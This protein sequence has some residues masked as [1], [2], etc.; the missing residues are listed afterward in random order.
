MGDLENKLS[1]LRVK[2]LKEITRSLDLKGRSSA[3]TKQSL[4]DFIINAQESRVITKK[5]LM[6]E[7]KKYTPT[8]SPK[9]RGSA[10][11]DLRPLLEQRSLVNLKK[12][13][14]VFGVPKNKKKDELID[15]LMKDVDSNRLKTE[16]EK[17][18]LLKKYQRTTPSPKAKRKK[19]TP[20]RKP[21]PKRKKAKPSPKVK[22]KRTTPSPEM[23]QKIFKATTEDNGGELKN[24]FES[25][26]R[27]K[28]EITFKCTQHGGISVS[29]MDEE[30]VALM[31]LEMKNT[32]FYEYYCPEQIHFGFNVGEVSKRMKKVGRRDTITME[33]KGDSLNFLVEKSKGDT[34][35]NF[36]VPL[37]DLKYDPL[38]V[39]FTGYD[40]YISMPSD[41]FY[42]M[43]IE[44]KRLGN[45][46]KFRHSSKI[47]IQIFSSKS[48]D[49]WGG[50]SVFEIED[51]ETHEVDVD[52]DY[53]DTI[54][55]TDFLNLFAKS[56][57][58]SK[59]VSIKL[60][61]EIPAVVTYYVNNFTVMRYYL[62]PKRPE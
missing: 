58:L 14:S 40:V 39:P 46:T 41:E 52:R 38:S 25:L 18:P 57:N 5:S 42:R 61:N 54:V 4:I 44:L 49:S 2:E 62:A 29:E 60:A 53:D 19:T 27:F 22:R 31:D 37:L 30:F 7:I 24:V 3:K 43:T 45:F 10:S 47:S 11:A 13:A 1:S 55:S 28:K 17:Y 16:V 6:E 48:I 56:K 36:S 15:A 23:E 50:D 12:A 32:N 8:K 33:I 35:W 34:E 20:T 26:A 21:K 59:K 9:R 51:D